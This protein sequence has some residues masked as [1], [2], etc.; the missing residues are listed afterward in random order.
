MRNKFAQHLRYI[1]P[2]NLAIPFLFITTGIV[3]SCPGLLSLVTAR[4]EITRYILLSIPASLRS[5]SFVPRVDA[6]TAEFVAEALYLTIRRKHLGGTSFVSLPRM[7][8]VQ[9]IAIFYDQTK[10]G[11]AVASILHAA[12]GPR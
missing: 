6:L 12:P 1:L 8:P 5:L 7:F 3:Q 4:S 2:C 10:E 9:G 11:F